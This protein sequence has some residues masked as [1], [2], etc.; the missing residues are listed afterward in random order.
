MRAQLLPSHLPNIHSRLCWPQPN[1]IARNMNVDY[2]PHNSIVCSV[3]CWRHPMLRL[4]VY[5]KVNINM[6][7][8]TDRGRIYIFKPKL[9]PLDAHLTNCSLDA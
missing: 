1:P 3:V 2:L 7:A 4:F 6:F 9:F 5:D 8:Q